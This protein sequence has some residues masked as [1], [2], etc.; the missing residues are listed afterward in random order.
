MS[1][2]SRLRDY[3]YEAIAALTGGI[4]LILEIVGARMI[5]PYFGTSTYIWAAMIGVILGSLSLGYYYGGRLADWRA[6]DQILALILAGTA[7]V[8]LLSLMVQQP[9]LSL[10]ASLGTDLRLQA[11][12]AATILFA[13][14]ST[15]M[16]LVSPY[17]AKLK[18]SS[19]KTAGRSIGRL[20]AA[21]TL[22]SITGTFLAGYWLI[23]WFGN[24]T[25]GLSL[26]AA[27][28]GVSFMANHRLLRWA[29][30]GLATAAMLLLLTPARLEGQVK[31]DIDSVYSRYQVLETTFRGRLARLLITDNFSIQSAQYVSDPTALP[32]DYTK[33]F[34]EA[35]RAFNYPRRVLVIG[36]GTYTF[37]AALAAECT[38]CQIDVVEIDPALDDLAE[39]YFNFKPQPNIDIIH[40]DGRVFLNR[41]QADYDLI[42]MD[43]FSSLTPPYQLT[44]RQALERLK[45][46]LKPGGAVVVNLVAAY[47]GRNE[48]LH[49]STTTYQQVFASTALHQAADGTPPH[50]RQNLIL[51]AAAAPATTRQ[52]SNQLQAEQLTLPSGGL[53]LA[54][55]HAPVEQLIH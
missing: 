54:D 2:W 33:R 36:G 16:G 25:L 8:L 27:L 4:I 26:V 40:Q 19:L 6:N 7:V 41:E 28:I 21:G 53:I 3:R 10:I 12:L 43:A 47:A 50:Q 44:T 5:A 45:E 34:M 55:D 52:I 14:A 29:R 23:A 49:A 39:K 35:A 13:P 37:P 42:F 9:I 46:H 38:Q 24:R 30:L 48:Y 1:R 31:A 18:L 22:G 20:Y 32:L 11:L 15:L 51:L 17:V